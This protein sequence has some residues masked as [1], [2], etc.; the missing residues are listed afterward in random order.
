VDAASVFATAGQS[1]V[2]VDIDTGQ[3]RVV[4]AQSR[5]LGVIGGEWLVY[6]DSA[7]SAVRAKARSLD[8]APVDLATLPAGTTAIDVDPNG[9]RLVVAVTE[10]QPDGTS[11]PRL[12]QMT[13]RP[14][15]APAR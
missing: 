5:A 12:R 7:G 8:G 13:I 6:V 11:V 2:L 4:A 3:Q 9:G 10:L 1:A 15:P 14:V